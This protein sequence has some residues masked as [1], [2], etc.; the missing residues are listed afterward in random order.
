[1][2]GGGGDSVNMI[3]SISTYETVCILSL[4]YFLSVGYSSKPSHSSLSISLEKRH[5]QDY[6]KNKRGRKQKYIKPQQEKARYEE[7]NR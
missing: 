5:I 7:S 3:S 4:G 1:M 2:L 6:F